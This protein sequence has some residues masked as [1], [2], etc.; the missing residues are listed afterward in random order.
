MPSPPHDGRAPRHQVAPGQDPPPRRRSRRYALLAIACVVVVGAAGF[1]TVRTFEDDRPAGDGSLCWGT[2]APAEIGELLPQSKQYRDTAGPL[3][4]PAAPE[5]RCAIFSG[6]TGTVFPELEFVIYR[7]YD[8]LVRDD[9][10]GPDSSVSTPLGN[11][12]LGA[13]SGSEGWVELPKCM[14]RDGER[15]AQLRV[16]IPVARQLLAETLVRTANRVRTQAG[17]SEGSLPPPEPRPERPS[18][19]FDAATLCG[20]PLAPSLLAARTDWVQLWSGRDERHEDCIVV[21][22]SAET[23][24]QSQPLIRVEVYRDELARLEISQRR[25]N[26]KAGEVAEATYSYGGTAAMWAICGN[27]AVSYMVGVKAA[28][29]PPGAAGPSDAAHPPGAAAGLPSAADLLY[30]VIAGSR[31][32]DGCEWSPRAPTPGPS[33][34]P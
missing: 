20:I 25:G 14:P 23:P 17:C 26:Q 32:R 27:G 28:A 2:L 11:S 16:R 15:Y 10:F 31:E 34:Q 8:A 4:Y 5:E 7:G 19:S 3:G 13:A 33:S 22:G 9:W 29:G 30:A 24:S 1:V 6:T 18:S 12:V 21:D